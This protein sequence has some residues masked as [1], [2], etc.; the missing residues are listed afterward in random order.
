[1][2]ENVLK[3]LGVTSERIERVKSRVNDMRLQVGGNPITSN[4]C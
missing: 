3:G 2:C 1:M 4:T